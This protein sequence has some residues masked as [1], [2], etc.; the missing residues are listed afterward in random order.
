M[1]LLK[2]TA[3]TRLHGCQDSIDKF[4]PLVQKYKEQA[5][6]V[7]VYVAEAHPTDGWSLPGMIRNVQTHSSIEER[8]AAAESMVE[9]KK[10]D[11][12]SCPVYLESMEDASVTKYSARPERLLI[13]HDAQVCF[14]F[15]SFCCC[16]APRMDSF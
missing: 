15:L 13:I 6:F 2:S 5:D 9:D 11:T 8:R 14:V 10:F 16:C 3:F 12:R 4:Q 7:T 1:S